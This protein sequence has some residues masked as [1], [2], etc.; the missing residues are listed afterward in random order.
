[1][2]PWGLDPWAGQVGSLYLTGFFGA[3]GLGHLTVSAHATRV[4]GTHPSPV[5]IPLLSIQWRPASGLNTR[6]PRPSWPVSQGCLV[7]PFVGTCHTQVSAVMS[8]SSPPEGPGHA[9][10]SSCALVGFF[11]PEAPHRCIP[12]PAH[13][14][15]RFISLVTALFGLRDWLFSH[16]PI[17]FLGTLVVPWGRYS[18]HDWMKTKGRFQSA[19]LEDLFQTMVPRGLRLGGHTYSG[20]VLIGSRVLVAATG[21]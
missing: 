18:W 19:L 21:S 9:L 16:W 6:D 17:L 5:E 7:L 20:T 12:R 14:F 1:M 11:L 10:E 3:H 8:A 4:R 13:L 15:H 2:D